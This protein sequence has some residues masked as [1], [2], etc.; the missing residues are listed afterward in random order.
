MYSELIFDIIQ[1]LT[2]CLHKLITIKPKFKN[3]IFIDFEDLK[4]N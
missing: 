4:K 2:I 3:H 1:F